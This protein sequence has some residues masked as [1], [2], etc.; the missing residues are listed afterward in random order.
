[1][2]E[3]LYYKFVTH[4][5]KTFNKSKEVIHYWKWLR[6]WEEFGLINTTEINQALGQGC[7][8]SGWKTYWGLP[9]IT[10]PKTEGLHSGLNFSLIEFK[11]KKKKNKR[12][13]AFYKS[14]LS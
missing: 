7:N 9:M 13:A 5:R 6:I 14:R 3:N 1:M 10:L 11:K 2:H 8:H 12:N 4:V